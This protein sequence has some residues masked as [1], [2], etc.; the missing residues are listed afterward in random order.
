MNQTPAQA[1]CEDPKEYT[2][3]WTNTKPFTNEL[4]N[5][6]KNLS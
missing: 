3:I 6:L 4:K 1:S 2:E 5:F